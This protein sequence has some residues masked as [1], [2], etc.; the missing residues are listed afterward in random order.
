L[1]G[2][3]SKKE[4]R[5][6]ALMRWSIEQCF[7]ECKDYLGMDHYESR[8][9][10]AWRRHILLTLIAHLFIIKLRIAFSRKPNVPNATPYVAGPVS[11]E[12]YLEAHMQMLSNEQISHPDISEMPT[13]SQ[14]FMTVGLIQK[15]VSGTF[16]KVGL[17]VEEVDYLLNKAES[18]FRSH[19]LATV[20]G[21]LLNAGS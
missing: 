19:S 4:I 6:P 16:P 14:Q 1:H 8:S 20:N 2:D 5:K 13:I 12:E 10:D 7:K 15:L 18:A 21:I 17:I 11:L 9:W 3:A